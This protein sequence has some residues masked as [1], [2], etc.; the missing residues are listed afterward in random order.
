MPA[1]GANLDLLQRPFELGEIDI[2]EVSVGLQAFLD[3][4]KAALDAW[5]SYLVA[6]RELEL[7]LGRELDWAPALR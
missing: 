4:Q 3:A 6:L 1:F 7:A 5:E 2:I